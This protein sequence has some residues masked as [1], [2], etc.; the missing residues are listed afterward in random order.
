[1]AA[2]EFGLFLVWLQFGSKEATGVDWPTGSGLVLV[3]PG[4]EPARQPACTQNVVTGVRQ[5]LLHG[6]T[7]KAVPSMVTA[8]LYEV[9]EDWELPI[10]A[11]E[12][13]DERV[14][15]APSPQGEGSA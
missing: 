9:A 6:I 10:E 4:A 12:G 2:E 13:G 3:G 11:R 8:Q 1:M 5:F 14:P 15:D 7:M